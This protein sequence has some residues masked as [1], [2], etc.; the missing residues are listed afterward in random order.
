MSEETRITFNPTLTCQ[1]PDG[2]R[3]LVH[4]SVAMLVNSTGSMCASGDLL[5]VA[6]SNVA[7]NLT[8]ITSPLDK[9]LGLTGYTYER[10]D[11]APG[12]LQ[13]AVLAQD[14]FLPTLQAV[15]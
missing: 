8:T 11:A 14:A 5:S 2:F 6:D 15:Q 4:D 7:A 1:A 12:T 3:W 10:T 9:V 13:T